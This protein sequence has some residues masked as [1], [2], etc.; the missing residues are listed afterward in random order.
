[1]V[2]QGYVAED[3]DTN[4]RGHQRRGAMN[5][6]ENAIENVLQQA[7]C[8]ECAAKGL[9]TDD[10]PDGGHHARHATCL[11]QVVEHRHARGNTGAGIAGPHHTLVGEQEALPHSIGM[12]GQSLHQFGLKD[13]CNDSGQQRGQEQHHERGPATGNHNAHEHRHKQEPGRYEEGAVECLH[14]EQHVSFARHIHHQARHEED[15]EGKEECGN[16]GVHH[17]AD[18]HEEVGA[19]DAGGQHRRVGEWRQLIAEVGTRDDG[20]RNPAIVEA[21]RLADAH[22]RHAHRGNRGPRR[23]N[24]QTDDGTKQTATDQEPLRTE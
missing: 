6:A 8:R 5:K 12:L 14:E 11:H 16:G 19:R 18:V 23:A 13:Q 2:G 20:T 17:V 1:M 7:R 15:G 22:Q 9:R 4:G 21:M 24:H 10:E 3:A